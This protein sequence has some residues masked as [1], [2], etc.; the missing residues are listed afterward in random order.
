MITIAGSRSRQSI[1]EAPRPSRRAAL[2]GAAALSAAT[3][4]AATERLPAAAGDFAGFLAS[5]WPAA[6]AAGVRRAT[7]E[8]LTADLQPDNGLP[9]GSGGQPEFERLLAEYYREAVGAGRVAR[10]RSLAAAEAATLADDERRYGVPGAIALAAWGMESDYGRAGTGTRDVLRTV[11]TLAWTRPDRP[12][13]RDEAVAAMVILDRG[14]IERRRLVGSWAG[15]MGAPQ[16][17]PSAYLKYAVGPAG[18]APDIWA[19][20]PDI[21][22]SIANFLAQEGWARGEPWIAEVILPAGFDFPTLHALA[23]DWAKL[24]RRRPDGAT[25]EGAGEAALFLPAGAAGPAFLL[26]PNYFTIKQYNNS[27]SY[28]LSLGS[29]AQRIAGA[30]PLATPWPAHAVRLSRSDRTFIQAR[31]AALGLYTGAPDGKFGPKARDAI[32]AYQKQAGL[33]PADGFATPALVA[34]LRRN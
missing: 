13:F 3:F 16:F 11:A 33:G 9:R 5:L 22:A 20:P 8:A 28:A 2:Q 23:A 7:F 19:S 15:A 31:L 17:L 25:V 21:L 1:S 27:D 6:E 18:A 24:G 30:A 34:S 12:A 4:L 32:H 26:F 14:T 29:L 10:G